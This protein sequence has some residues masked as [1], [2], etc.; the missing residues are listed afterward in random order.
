[1]YV[2]VKMENDMV[3]PYTKEGNKVPIVI[4]S[5]HPRFTKGTRL[6]WG[7]AEIAVE[8]GYILTIIP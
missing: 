6:D 5:D 3:E 1:M 8:N 4:E 7:F 2:I